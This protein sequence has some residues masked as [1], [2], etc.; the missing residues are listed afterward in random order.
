MENNNNYIPPVLP[1]ECQPVD[2]FVV[3]NAVKVKS[4]WDGDIEEMWIITMV[5]SRNNIAKIE[6]YGIP[7]EQTVIWCSKNIRLSKLFVDMECTILN[8]KH[9][10]EKLKNMID[11]GDEIGIT[12]KNKY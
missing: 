1:R 8:R 7:F 5:S 9:R 12:I 11:E 6:L 10:L 2:R 3:G 4:E